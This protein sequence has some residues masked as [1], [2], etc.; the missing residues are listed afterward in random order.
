MFY[1][2]FSEILKLT[3]LLPN[4]I[5]QLSVSLN[6]Q[7]VYNHSWQTVLVLQNTVWHIYITMETDTEKYQKGKILYRY[8]FQCYCWYSCYQIVKQNGD[9]SVN[10][11]YYKYELIVLF[12]TVIFS[13]DQRLMIQ[14]PSNYILIVFSEWMRD[15]F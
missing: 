14:I 15:Y 10:D 11:L 2:Y 5:F 1:D 13:M 3:I 8:Y 6:L 4:I 7:R 9:F 12:Q